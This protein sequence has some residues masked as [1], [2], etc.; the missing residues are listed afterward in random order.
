VPGQGHGPSPCRRYAHRCQHAPQ[1]A[2]TLN[3][4]ALTTQMPIGCALGARQRG[5][6]K[7]VLESACS[8]RKGEGRPWA[9]MPP[10]MPA[11]STARLYHSGQ[12][13]CLPDSQHRRTN[14]GS[15]FSPDG[16]AATVPGGFILAR[17]HALDCRSDM[18]W[19]CPHCRRDTGRPVFVHAS[20]GEIIVDAKC[21]ACGRE[22]T[23]TR[24][25]LDLRYP[26]VTEM[27]DQRRP[28]K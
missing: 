26:R 18:P 21:D 16:L 7:S 27:R 4:R 3:S 9:S 22:W 8:P 13:V 11:R 2:V 5:H 12:Q 10:S 6:T 28:L 23:V 14:L 17:S 15:A 24:Q 20:Q 19:Q 25:E 1:R